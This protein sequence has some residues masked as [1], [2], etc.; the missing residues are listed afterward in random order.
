MKRKLTIKIITLFP[1]FIKAFVENF[2]IIR[3]AVKNKLLHIQAVNLRDF[4]IDKRQTVDDRPYGGEIGMVLRPD[5]LY[6][7]IQFVSRSKIKDKRSKIILLTPQGKLFNQETAQKLAKYDQLVLICGRYEG[8]DERIRKFVDEEISIG[9]YVLMGGELPALV[10]AE[11]VMRLRAGILGKDESSLNESFSTIPLN[12]DRRQMGCTKIL[13]YPQYTK[14]EIWPAF[15]KT[16]AG[17]KI[18]RILRVPKILL[19]GNHQKV[20][21]W[22]LKEAIR[23]TKKRRPDLFKHYKN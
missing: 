7:A 20:N 12:D 10:I 2:G 21:E 14:P 17:K 19:S 18:K 15:V 9:D 16:S 23:R 4:G 8:F 11:S 3:K 5:V 13:E 1:E 6:K 22:R